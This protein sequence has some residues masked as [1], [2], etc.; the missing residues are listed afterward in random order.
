MNSRKLLVAS[1]LTILVAGVGTAIRGGLLL[2]WGKVFGFTQTELG[3]ITGGGFAGFGCVI[4]IASLFLDKFGYK[5]FLVLAAG[6]HIVSVILT[7]AATFAYSSKVDTDPEAAK[8]AAY[9][10]LFWGIFI[11]AVANGICE[12]V[13]N[14]LIA[15]LYSKQKTHYLNILHAGWP[16]GMIVGALLGIFLIGRVRWEIVLAL[17]LVPTLVYL[18]MIVREKFPESEAAAAGVSFG[19]MLKEFAAPVLLFLLLLHACIGYVELGTDSWIVNI[20]DNVLGG[21][22]LFILLYTS[23]LMFVLRF[24]AGPIAH[25][26]SPLGLLFVSAI[27]A[28]IGLYALGSFSTL[29]AIMV[30]ATVYG[31]GKTFFW[32]TMLSVV[33]ERFPRGG[34]LTLGA[35]GGVGM[36]SAG[37]LGGPGLGY[38]QDRYASQNLQETS[39]ELYQEYAADG[40]NQFLFFPEVRGLDGSKTGPVLEKAKDSTQTLT[41]EEQAVKDSSFYGGQMALKV[42]AVVPAAMAIGFLILIVYFRMQGGY[43]QIVLSSSRQSEQPATEES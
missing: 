1:F 17:Y 28:S 18:L 41:D 19:E 16:G 14:P 27:L 31:I 21:K 3:Q 13:I 32:P 10:C 37:F 43:K 42:T 38:T 26:I 6:L 40:T 25:R 35:I 4:L 23:I 24:F 15:T 12:A 34:A 22:G 30:A 11:F 7:A 2:E 36:L 20:M 9:F 39:L 33:S 8:S 29:V 5:P